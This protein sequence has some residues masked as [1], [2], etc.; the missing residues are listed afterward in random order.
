MTFAPYHVIYGEKRNL[1]Y[2]ELHLFRNRTSVVDRFAV[3]LEI[4]FSGTFSLASRAEL[5]RFTWFTFK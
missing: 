3:R 1:Q 2:C 5:G 4:E